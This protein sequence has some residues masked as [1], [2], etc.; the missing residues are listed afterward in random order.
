MTDK[1]VL[2]D[3]SVAG[4]SA[5]GAMLETVRDLHPR[6]IEVTEVLRNR[7]TE[8]EVTDLELAY[9]ELAIR[10]VEDALGEVLKRVAE[11]RKK[12]AERFLRVLVPRGVDGIVALGKKFTVD[13]EL[14]P[15]PPPYG[16][17]LH[18]EMLRW[19]AESQYHDKVKTDVAW[20]SLKAIVNELAEQGQPNPPGV[21][22]FV[23]PKV[24]VK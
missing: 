16:S 13:S 19:F 20:Q 11:L 24:K 2:D 18:V 10:E 8:V 21:G 1:L 7:M 23:Q 15:K 3:S 6:A 12:N 5:L 14:A 4:F 17:D 22:T 9:H